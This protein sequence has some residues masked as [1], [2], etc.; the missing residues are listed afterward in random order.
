MST[1]QCRDINK[2]HPFVQKVAEAFLVECRKQGLKIK[3]SETFRT[4]ERQDYLYAQGRTR[5]G[6]I[7]T[8]AKGRD[9]QSYHQWGLAFDIY[10][11]IPNDIYN[12]S[13]MS[14][15]I[16]IAKKMGLESGDSWGDTP[17]LQY[18]FGLSIAQLK[19]GKKPPEAVKSDEDLEKAVEKLVVRNIIGS[20][21]AWSSIDKINLKNV[22]ALLTKM[23]GVD[24]LVKDKI[25]SDSLLWATGTY[26][27]EHVR[28]LIIKY[29]NLG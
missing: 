10:V 29:A 20:P 7:V 23:G 24:R 5:A 17:H 15:A 8:N 12:K 18:T 4:K 27:I 3:I 14:K 16:A 6:N 26:K 13:I 21:A 28:S 9:M 22:P 2:L 25:I 11:D 19:S 1:E